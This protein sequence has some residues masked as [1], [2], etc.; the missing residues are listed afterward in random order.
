[1]FMF[2]TANLTE[3]EEEEEEDQDAPP[4]A[5]HLLERFI[6][7]DRRKR[8]RRSE[9]DTPLPVKHQLRREEAVSDDCDWMP[10][11]DVP[12]T[13]LPISDAGG[14]LPRGGGGGG[15]DDDD[16]SAG[17]VEGGGLLLATPTFG[18]HY[19]NHSGALR[20][21]LLGQNGV[22]KTSLAL[23]LAGQ[24]D[25]SLSIDSETMACGEG[26]E[27][28]VTVDDEDSKLLIYDNWKQRTARSAAPTSCTSVA[29]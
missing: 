18:S 25:R 3:E 24:S 29:V 6:A 13:V 22:G 9:K 8:R 28:S 21:V 14:G 15:D 11:L 4:D 1:M 23:S 26:Y 17:G 16:D 12:P 5:E 2:L 19:G 20:I 10:G 27:R 7:S